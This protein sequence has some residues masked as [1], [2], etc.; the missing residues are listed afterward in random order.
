MLI[1]NFTWIYLYLFVSILCFTLFWFTGN[2]SVTLPSKLLMIC[3][4]FASLRLYY[5][6][7]NNTLKV[8]H[9]IIFMIIFT[10][11]LI[12]AISYNYGPIFLPISPLKSIAFNFILGFAATLAILKDGKSNFVKYYPFFAIFI[13]ATTPFLIYISGVEW[14]AD[15]ST[16]NL[17]QTFS[18]YYFRILILLIILYMI[19]RKEDNLWCIFMLLILFIFSIETL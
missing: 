3:S 6:R 11:T 14:Y 1:N 18:V 9:L 7:C 8:F 4:F 17:Y 10:K 2:S 12:D 19:S 5:L 15:S 16:I 13:L